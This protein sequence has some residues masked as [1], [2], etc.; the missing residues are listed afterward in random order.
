M[1][2]R[3]ELDIV[4]LGATGY[5][6]Y[7]CAEHIT[8]TSPT[9]LRGAIASRSAAALEAVSERLKC[10]DKDRV[11]PGIEIVQHNA[12]NLNRLTAKARVVI[13]T[14]GPFSRFSSPI[15]ETCANNRNIISARPPRPCGSG[16]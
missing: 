11:P 2:T 7:L 12:A 15:V 9:T 8:K 10:I 16:K 14:I 13:N 5:T 3:R 6:G 4:L 1:T